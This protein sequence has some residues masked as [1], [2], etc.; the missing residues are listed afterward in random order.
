MLPPGVRSVDAPR[1]ERVE[2]AHYLQFFAIWDALE[3]VSACQASES[4]Y[5][6]KGAKANWLGELKVGVF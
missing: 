4:S 2:F 1:V 3:R 5:T 6:T